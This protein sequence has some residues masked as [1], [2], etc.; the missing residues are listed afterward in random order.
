MKKRVIAYCLLFALIFSSLSVV[1]NG[2][3]SSAAGRKYIMGYL[4]SGKK[5][6]VSFKAKRLTVSGYYMTKSSVFKNYSKNK[7]HGKKTYKVSTNCAAEIS[8]YSIFTKQ[9]KKKSMSYPKFRKKCK[10][11][12]WDKVYFTIKGNK[13]TKIHLSVD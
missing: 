11:Y 3:V 1:Q 7:K 6:K 12:S 2:S 9:Y 5:I 4:D 10:N 13:V 8:S